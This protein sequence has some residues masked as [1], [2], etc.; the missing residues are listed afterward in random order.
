MAAR[1][2]IDRAEAPR[3]GPGPPDPGARYHARARRPRRSTVRPS[4]STRRRR[5]IEVGPRIGITKAAER[6]VALRRGRLEV[7]QQTDQARDRDPDVH[8]GRSGDAGPRQLEDRHV[9]AAPCPPAPLRTWSPRRSHFRCARSTRQADQ[10]RHDAVRRLRHDQRHV[11]VG[12]QTALASAS[13]RARRSPCRPG[14]ADL[15]DDRRRQRLAGEPARGRPRSGCA[16]E[17][18]NVDLV[19]LAVRGPAGLLPV[20]EEHVPRRVA[21]PVVELEQPVAEDDLLRRSVRD[22]RRTGT[23][24]ARP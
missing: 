19:R 15:V 4:S 17:I 1:R 21:V 3:R 14:L 6:A 20:E 12:R 13:A 2:G 22:V 11:V 10:L 23:T 18:R 9:P 24:P 5:E 7:P 8:P 16:D